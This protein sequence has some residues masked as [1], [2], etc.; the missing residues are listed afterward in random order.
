MLRARSIASPSGQTSCQ[1][2]ILEVVV[3]VRLFISSKAGR[4]IQATAGPLLAVLSLSGCA[5]FWDDVTSRDFQF[6][7][8]FVQPDPLQ[9]LQTSNDGD[10]RRKALQALKEPISHGGTQADQDEVMKI[11]TN[12]AISDKQPDL[13][14]GGHADAG[15][16]KD[17]RAPRPSWMPLS[18]NS[19]APDTTAMLQCHALKS[20]GETNQ[21]S[22][23]RTLIR[24]VR[25]RSEGTEVERQTPWDIRRRR[26]MLGHFSDQCPKPPSSW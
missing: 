7:T 24:V 19:F 11:L 1:A 13:P 23:H 12:T 6:K 9:V 18:A 15:R 20:L 3:K 16:F 17:P 14:T 8:L 5:S 10:H 25:E 4:R 2:S 21:Q 22:R 26:Q